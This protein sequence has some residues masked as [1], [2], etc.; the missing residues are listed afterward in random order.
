MSTFL[1]SLTLAPV[2]PAT[3]AF[4]DGGGVRPWRRAVTAG[5]LLAAALYLLPADM[6]FPARLTLGVFTAAVLGWTLLRADDI[7]VALLAALAL[8]LGGAVP[9]E[10]LHRALGEDLVWL[11]VGGFLLAAVLRESGL[12]QRWALQA[13]AGAGSLAQLMR[14]LTVLIAATAFLV[15]STSGRATLLL[16]VF[17]VLSQALDRPAATRAL[18]LLFPTTILLSAGASM[19]GAGAHLMALDALRAQGIAVPGFLGWAALSAPVS[20]AS[21]AL[22]C[23]TIERLMLSPQER[24]AAV[25]LPAAPR[26]PLRRQQR[27]VAW[28]VALTV[29]GWAVG[30][31]LGLD[32]VIVALAGS[33]AA[34]MPRWTGVSLA[35]AMKGVEWGLIL[36]LAATGLMADALIS[37]GAAAGL[38]RHAVDALPSGAAGAWSLLVGAVL[39][40]LLAHLLIVSRSARVVVLLPVLGLPLAA[41]GFDPLASTLLLTLASGFCQTLVVSAKPLGVYARQECAG[42]RPADLLRLSLVLLL[43]VAALLLACAVWVWPLLGLALRAV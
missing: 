31:A 15:P 11:M 40:A 24:H 28:I 38:A 33:L 8:V 23:L 5:L 37:T 3:A 32:A 18:A 12:A 10:R 27:S 29:A 42:V 25:V 41:A 9:A 30:P 16:P 17:L 34:T 36:F 7:V 14:R 19:L 35:A 20:W 6:G 21:C 13:V 2:P 26:T 22:A 43:P 1:P 39:L 4:A